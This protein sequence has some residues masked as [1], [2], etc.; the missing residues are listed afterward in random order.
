M[1]FVG[2]KRLDRCGL[3]LIPEGLYFGTAG[4]AENSWPVRVP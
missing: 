3:F 1:E 4:M 2:V